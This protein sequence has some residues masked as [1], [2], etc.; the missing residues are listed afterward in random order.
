VQRTLLLSLVAASYLLLAGA[1][2]WSLGPLVALAAV[3]AL[4]APRRTFQ[5]PREHRLLDVALAALVVGIAVQLLPLPTTVVDTISP[6]AARIKAALQFSTASAPALTALSIAPA[7]TLDALATAVIGVL[8]FWTARAVFGASGNT[9]AFCRML[10]LL[11][12]VAALAAI[13]QKAATP[14]LLLFGVQPEARS[15]NPFGA[16]TNRNHFAGWLLLISTPVIGY[17]VARLRI[18]EYRDRRWSAMVKQFLASGAVMTALSS[19][20]TIGTLALTLSRSA[21]AGLGAAA[22]VGWQFGR[23]RMRLDHTTLPTRL[24][25]LAFAGVLVVLSMMFVDVDGWATRIEESFT[26][27]GLFGRLTIWKETLPIIGDFWLTG[28]GAGAY[29]DAMTYY[30]QTRLFVSS[31]QRWAHFNNAHSHFI[32]IAAEGGVL[33]AVPAIAALAALWTLARRALRAD[34]GE[35][36]WVRVGAAAGLAGLMV[37]SIWEVSLTMPANAV[38][39]GVLAGLLLYRREPGQASAG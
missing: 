37:Q 13:A 14:K 19:T 2:P 21:V 20:V 10:A 32:Q 29:S 27:E 7:R 11:G 33:L 12:L 18:H 25:F 23:P 1:R 34:K 30:Q 8:S 4:S 22:I 3:A 36:F 16:F 6:N 35:M 26:T 17:L 5:F 31:M 15:T 39:T 28:V 38:L 9:R 24:G